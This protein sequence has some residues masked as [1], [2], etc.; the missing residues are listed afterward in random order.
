MKANNKVYD[1]PENLSPEQISFKL[2]MM[3]YGENRNK[4]RRLLECYSTELVTVDEW[5]DTYCEK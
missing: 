4:R 2:A 1:N 3:G 5:V